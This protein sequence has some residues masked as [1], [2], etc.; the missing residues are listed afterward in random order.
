[1]DIKLFHSGPM[2]VNSYICADEK[3]GRGF[4]LDPGGPNQTADEYIKQHGYAVEYIILTHGH[5]DHICGVPY[6]KDKFNAKLVGHHG[7]DF[8]FSNEREN[9][10]KEFIGTAVTFAC[11]LYVNDGDILKIGGLEIKVL[12]T[13]GH[14]PG[15]IC[16]LVEDMLFS[17]DTLFA[18]SIGRTDFQGGSF[19]DIKKSIQ[20]KLYVLPDDTQVLPGH[21][22][23]TTIGYEKINNFFV[24]AV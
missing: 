23:A 2:Q 9:L 8:L 15:G 13:P 7:D 3:T 16:L 18:Q 24:K 22:G 19:A 1:M 20:E 10:S 14:T 17:G 6:Y 12:H 4:I 21:M 5:G 11:D